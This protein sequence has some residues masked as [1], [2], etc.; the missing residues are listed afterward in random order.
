MTIEKLDKI[1]IGDPETGE[2][3][4]TYKD[5]LD[6]MGGISPQFESII[7]REDGGSE[8]E[9]HW[10][11]YNRRLQYGTDLIAVKFINGKAYSKYEEG[12][13]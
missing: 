12:L 10:W 3:G 5:D 6:L 9:A 2:G 7:E 1:Y 13:E 8:V 11:R 4:M